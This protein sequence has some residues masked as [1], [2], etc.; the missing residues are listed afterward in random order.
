MTMNSKRKITFY[1][2]TTEVPLIQ[3]CANPF[4]NVYESGIGKY[5]SRD[6]EGT[7]R[8]GTGNWTKF[9]ELIHTFDINHSVE[10]YQTCM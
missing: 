5:S 4:N 1:P 9:A 8:P 10:K 3:D 6:P 2:A 7:Y